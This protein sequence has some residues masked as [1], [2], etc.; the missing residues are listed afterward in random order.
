MPFVPLHSRKPLP[1]ILDGDKELIKAT[2]RAK[3]EK[4]VSHHY[5]VNPSGAGYRFGNHPMTMGFVRGP[6][7]PFKAA[8]SSWRPPS[9]DR[10]GPAR[11]QASSVAPLGAVWEGSHR[12]AATNMVKSQSSPALG[13]EARQACH[14]LSTE[15]RRWERLAKV[16]ERGEVNKDLSESMQR[17]PAPVVE[18]KPAGASGGLIMFPKYMLFNNCHLKHDELKRFQKAQI[19]EQ[20]RLAEIA[21]RSPTGSAGAN[22]MD[23]SSVGEGAVRYQEASWGAPLL[24]KSGMGTHF[25]G[26]AMP[27]G[28]GSRHSNPFRIG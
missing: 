24:R 15:L 11:R 8:T 14:P 22:S 13:D 17:K 23:L 19:A 10:D 20:E 12:M 9:A 2:Q 5:G 4:T 27:G 26:S 7:V 25:A 21:S 6:D 18:D 1:V 16:T 3:D 28:R